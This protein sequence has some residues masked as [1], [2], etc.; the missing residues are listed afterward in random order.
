[1]RPRLAFL[2]LSLHATACY[3]PPGASDG[4]S[5]SASAPDSDSEVHASDDESGPPDASTT[6]PA[7]D[8]GTGT[9]WTTWTTGA[10]ETSDT[11]G[12]PTTAAEPTTGAA[13]SSGGVEEDQCPRLRVLVP[14]GEVLNVRPT[15][16]TAIA[17]LGTLASGMLVEVVDLVAGE[18]LEGNDQWY[19]I[20]TPKLDGFVWSG[21]VECTLDEPPTDGFFL[22]LECGVSAKISQGNFGD[23]SHQGKSSHAFDFQLASGT[24]LVA[25]A[26]GTVAALYAGT[27][28]GDPCYNGGGQECNSAANYVTLLHGDGTMSVYGHLSAVHVEKGE[29]VPRGY[30]IGLSGSTGWSTGPHAHVARQQNCALGWCQSIEVTFTDVAGDGVPKTGDTVTSGNC[31]P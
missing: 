12:E 26:E 2:A 31:P 10:A 16:S 7:A 30:P 18:S 29:L 15:P 23:F 13:S 19:E 8:P 3:S 11:T 5:S 21:L 4:L 27:K 20:H 9:T 1:M 28:P 17:P 22:P 14:P 24:P 25:I 6:E